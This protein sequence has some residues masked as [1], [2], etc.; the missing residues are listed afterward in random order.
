M[1]F[2]VGEIAHVLGNLDPAGTEFKQTF[3]Q[4]NVYMDDRKFPTHLRVAL[5]DFLLRS[6]GVFRQV[7]VVQSGIHNTHIDQA[8]L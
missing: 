2:M 1:S 6:D 8:H 4:L 7:N 3:D 5:R